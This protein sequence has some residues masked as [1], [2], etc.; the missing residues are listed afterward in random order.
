[1]TE[2]QTWV[3]IGVFSAISVAFFVIAVIDFISVV[4]ESLRAGRGET[5]GTSSD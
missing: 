2:A 1:M 5:R 4:R 3:V